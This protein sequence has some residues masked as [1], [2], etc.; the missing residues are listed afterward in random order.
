MN[1][2]IDIRA[3]DPGYY[4]RPTPFEVWENRQKEKFEY[5][6]QV[7]KEVRDHFFNRS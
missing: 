5:K 1:F 6:Y 7:K 3:Q 2:L 4:E